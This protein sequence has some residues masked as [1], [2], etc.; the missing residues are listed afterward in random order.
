MHSQLHKILAKVRPSAPVEVGFLLDT[1]VDLFTTQQALIQ[2]QQELIKNQQELIKN[3]DE[4]IKELEDRLDR[5][6]GNSSQP[7]SSDTAWRSPKKRSLRPPSTK[8]RGGQAGHRGQGGKLSDSPDDV[9]LFSVDRCPGCAQDLRHV[10]PLSW[11]TK[12]LV[13][14]PPI[15]RVVTEYRLATKQCP[16]CRARVRAR[17]CPIDHQMEFGPRL[18]AFCVYL[19]TYQ[20]VPVERTAELLSGMLGV[21]ISTGSLDNFRRSAN[22]L[23]GPFLAD[24]RATI[25]RASAA[26]FDETGIRVD[27]RRFW[28]HTASTDQHSLFTL[29]KQRGGEVHDR[30][31]ILPAFTG[32]AHHDALAA[33]HVFTGAR[34]SLCNAHLLRELNGVQDREAAG[35]A[36]DWAGELKV[37]L[38]KIKAEV[39][40][41]TGSKLGASTIRNYYQAFDDLIQQGL[42]QH[43]ARGRPKTQRRGV[44]KQGKTH[45]LLQRLK[46]RRDNYLLFM[47]ESAAEFDNNQ[48]ERDLRM[49]KVKMKV[50]GCFRSPEAGQEF[51]NIRSLVGTA[52]KQACDPIDKLMELFR[53][54][55]AKVLALAK[56]PE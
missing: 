7:P 18:K 24:L 56:Y 13:D 17:G 20:L 38:L 39:A 37:L 52:I 42:Q 32:I 9:V 10:S 29:D 27:G 22:R 34:H 6:S 43:P 36:S 28:G 16:A 21:A 51:M 46:K 2:N 14:L 40:T 49:L 41:A 53:G 11:T 31:G 19:S 54:E 5:H 30:I 48:A 15:Q 44:T 47:T 4:R 12:Q 33:Y 35:V 50:S 26:Y 23:L 25:T 3:Q 8:P 45:N 55:S 1:L